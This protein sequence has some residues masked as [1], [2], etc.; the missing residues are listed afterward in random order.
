MHPGPRVEEHLSG[1]GKAAPRNGHLGEHVW[2][3]AE[4]VF[5][6]TAELWGCPR[7]WPSLE[8]CKGA[9]GPHSQAVLV[10]KAHSRLCVR[11]L[12]SL[13]GP[14]K[15]RQVSSFMAGE[16]RA[17]L[18]EENLNPPAR[19]AGNSSDCS[20][21]LTGGRGWTR[22]LVPQTCPTVRWACQARCASSRPR[23]RPR[24]H[25]PAQTQA[26][27]LRARSRGKG[28]AGG[29]MSAHVR[30]SASRDTHVLS[31]AGGVLSFRL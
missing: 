6:H 16:V 9:G 11:L 21:R 14:G 23:P 20:F 30:E 8:L 7:P 29:A 2:P 13:R 27:E 1:H 5:G 10:S 25:P 15:A 22:P 19:P 28:S 31:E 17:L 24:A 3:H 18:L 26:R 4:F 12:Q